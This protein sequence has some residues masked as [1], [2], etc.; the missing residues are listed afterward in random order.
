[1]IPDRAGHVADWEFDK[2]V[3]ILLRQF[4]RPL[5]AQNITLSNAQITQIGEDAAER[6]PLNDNAQAVRAALLAVIAESE[7][8]LAQWKLTFAQS[9]RTEMTDMPGWETTA[10]F[11]DV[12]NEKINAEVRISAGASLLTVLGDP[13]HAS[14]LLQAIDHDLHTDGRLDVDAM[15]AKRT[16]LHAA[17]IPAEADDWLDQARVWV[18]AQHNHTT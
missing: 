10:D 11:L 2:L 1:M 14:Y 12:A 7:A 9:L 5:E 13:R 4:K 15:I 16:L 8:V 6:R 18:Q 3:V 17:A